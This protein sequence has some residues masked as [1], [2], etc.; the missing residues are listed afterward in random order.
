[1]K[2]PAKSGMRMLGSAVLL[3]LLTAAPLLA[4]ESDAA[5]AESASSWAFRWLNFAAVAGLI[6]FA[7]RKAA[8]V[9]RRRAEEISGKIAEGARAREAA[10]KQRR[11]VRAKINGIDAEVAGLRSDAKR[12]TA[13]EAERIRALAKTEA[14]AVERAARAEIGA[15]E[16]AARLELK[17]RAARMAVERAEA[18]LR[19]NLTPNAEAALIRAFVAEIERSPN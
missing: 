13:A 1:M 15:A 8:P 7:L 9:F 6:L 3:A 17:A 14:E 12:A 16:R 19:E 2:F 11:E 18:L 5:S 10:E 4:Q